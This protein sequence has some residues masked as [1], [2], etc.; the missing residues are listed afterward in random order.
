MFQKKID[1]LFSGILNVFGIA[2]ENLIAGFDERSKD[3]DEIL[4]KVLW[5]CR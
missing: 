1:E 4:E 2:D 5:I 3:H